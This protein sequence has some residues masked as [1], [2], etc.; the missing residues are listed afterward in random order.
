MT[1]KNMKYYLATLGFLAVTLFLSSCEKD[2]DDPQVDPTEVTA[3]AGGDIQAAINEEITL[4][5]SRST[6]SEGTLSYLWELTASP[7][8]SSAKI[9]DATSRRASLTP[10]KQGAYDI[11]LTVSV[12][13]TSK[14]DN[15]T[16]TAS[17]GPIELPCSQIN[18]EMTLDKK[19][20]G[21]VYHVPCM[22]RVNA[23]LII[24]P[25]VTVQF[26]QDAG[27]ELSDSGSREGYL[28][29]EGTEQDSIRFTGVLKSEGAWDQLRINSGDLRNSMKYCIV[30]YAGM[31][32]GSKAA[33]RVDSDGKLQ[34][35]NSLVRRSSGLGMF[36]SYAANITG[37]ANNIFTENRSYPLHIAANKVA[38]LDGLGSTYTGNKNEAGENRDEIY[39][40][41][42]S[43]GHITGQEPHVWSDPGVPFF[44]DE[45]L[46]V[47]KS[48][49]GT[50]R[51]MPGCEL[52]FGQ[53]YGMLIDKLNSSLQVMGSADNKVTFRGRNGQGSWDG[54]YLKT[55][56]IENIIQYAVITD[57]GQSKMSNKFN[58]PANL[59]LG[60]SN[61]NAITLSLD[62][63]E[64][65][66]SGG[67][68]IVQYGS[69]NLTT[70]NVTFSENAGDDYCE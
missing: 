8:G 13:G 5:G 25:G 17:S 32:D 64:I 36:V 67:C 19:Y 11:K 59:S 33:I 55:N 68:G 41:S 7:S 1:L 62:H 48:D 52:S 35:K 3:D 38:Q 24:E 65:N 21:V 26:A 70:N 40:A 61:S 34:L 47:G 28:K 23:G 60:Y 66:N 10:D 54:I 2:E 4:D 58:N 53:N 44:I 22:I 30:E 12:G 16:V 42:N 31:Q 57:G 15:I 63:V 27:F 46:Y 43:R 69:V 49:E 9:L 20:E 37:F 45:L 39:V 14:S 6:T 29:A 50:L 51:I 18:E 56:N